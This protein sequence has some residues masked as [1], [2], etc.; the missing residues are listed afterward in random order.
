MSSNIKVAV[1]L[2]P[3]DEGKKEKWANGMEIHGRRIVMGPRTFDPDITLDV[4]SNQADVFETCTPILDCVRNGNNGTI[5]VY[6][7]TGTG[8]T[9][10]MLGPGNSSLSASNPDRGVTVRAV[11]Y[12]LQH[13]TERVMLGSK[14]ALSLS[15]LEI[16]NERITDMLVPEQPLVPLYGG[17]PH[18]ATKEA[19]ASTDQAIATIV[20]GLSFRHVA[21]TAM[22]DRSSRSHVIIMLHVEE[23][24]DDSEEVDVARLFLVDLA[25]SESIKKSQVAGKAA[26]EAGLINKSLLALKGVIMALSS[27]NAEQ[28]GHVPYR[29]SRLTEMLQDSI[30]GSARTMMIACISPVGRDVEET[31]S[32]LDYASKAR[33]IRNLANTERDK[34]A[35]RIRSLEMDL[36]KYRNQLQD[37]INERNGV[38]VPKEA[39]ER[40]LSLDDSKEV[41]QAEVVQ[42]CKQLEQAEARRN[43]VDSQVQ[44]FKLAAE[45]KEEELDRFR[46]AQLEVITKFER[47]EAEMRTYFSQVMND[48]ATAVEADASAA[49]DRLDSFK[50]CDLDGDTAV[51][52]AGPDIDAICAR[53]NAQVRCV[54]ERLQT[55]HQEALEEIMADDATRT[56]E[57]NDALEEVQ[58][59]LASMSRV[60][61][62]SAARLGATCRTSDELFRLVAGA[63]P[64]AD[65]DSI[66]GVVRNTVGTIHSSID[67]L[68]SS[69]TSSAVV[70]ATNV[71]KLSMQRASR[72]V[73]VE[74]IQSISSMPTAEEASTPTYL[75]TTPAL[76]QA[77]AESRGSTQAFPLNPPRLSSSTRRA[78]VPHKENV[79]QPSYMAAKGGK[80]TRSE[81]EDGGRSTT[82]RRTTTGGSTQI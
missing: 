35:V 76:S 50:R 29:D 66:R 39:Y 45:R 16:Y 77:S 5:L 6:G 2:R 9:H 58:R 34:M 4:S 18:S 72:G 38:W 41:L 12:L 13:V 61:A 36:Q 31:K 28:R 1:R 74:G 53:M 19:L 10:T 49:S 24:R 60:N 52:T 26:G 54:I 32:T 67:A 42:M 14:A 23:Q 11:D 75:P 3:L 25:G 51:I 78:L 73:T 43:I 55:Q 48:V 65:A 82:G 62:S 15:M 80:R 69:S 81:A 40:Y 70:A 8:K 57:M 17:F 33:T 63:P 56:R 46:R 7:Q 37:K 44:V 79:P 27:S 30:G 68:S 64:C 20:R 47:A 71:A 22:N 59:G 21:Q